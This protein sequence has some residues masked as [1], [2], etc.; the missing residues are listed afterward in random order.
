MLKIDTMYDDWWG[1]DKNVSYCLEKIIFQ[2]SS[3]IEHLS[4]FHSGGFAGLGSIILHFI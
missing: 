1:K 3:D 4:L 2:S